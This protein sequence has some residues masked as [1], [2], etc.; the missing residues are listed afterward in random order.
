[1]PVLQKEF[2]DDQLDTA[3]A[4]FL[5]SQVKIDKRKRTVFLPK[6]CDVYALDFGMGD[7][8]VCLSQCL[9]Y[10]DESSQTAIA[11]LL[12]NGVVSVKFNN[13]VCDHFHS[14]LTELT[15]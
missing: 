11:E 13:C 3:S 15:C 5:M 12:E 7:G 10:L 2:L 8:L 14:S 1:V 9:K 6:V 4:C